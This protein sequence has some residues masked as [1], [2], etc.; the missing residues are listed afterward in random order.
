MSVTP[1][2][3]ATLFLIGASDVPN[4]SNGRTPTVKTLDF[5]LV[6]DLRISS[7]DRDDNY[8]WAGFE[9]AVSAD[10]A[11]NMYIIDPRENRII[12]LDKDGTFIRSIGQKGEGPGEF[13][14]LT[15]MTLLDDQTIVAYD[16]RSPGSFHFFDAG[17]KFVRRQALNGP[18]RNNL[19]DGVLS[20]NGRWIFGR[21]TR[22]QA[23]PNVVFFEYSLF[24]NKMEKLHSL[25]Q[26]QLDG[27]DPSRQG[28]PAFWKKFLA[29][30]IGVDG[31]GLLAYVAY[32]SK[33]EVYTAV[34]TKYEITRWTPDMVEDLRI[35]RDY[36]PIVLSE[37]EIDAIVSPIFAQA[38]EQLPDEHKHILSAAMIK[39]SV[40]LAGFPPAKPPILGLKVTDQ[41]ILVVIHDHSE[42]S[43]R[44]SADLFDQK[45]RF[46][47][48]F[49]HE[50][51]GLK[52]M[53]FKNGYAYTIETVDEENELVRYKIN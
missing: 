24:N 16:I 33:G 19:R 42:I 1:L 48:R 30:R 39:E 26:F 41:G 52:R 22:I 47:G 40:E 3:L 23:S 44:Q 43:G 18:D 6:E 21:T 36:K 9:V 8:V 45:G 12:Q 11:G 38:K 2:M 7:D 17:Y 4:I 50:N 10:K 20:P 37:Q 5:Q 13:R 53:F 35:T 15:G 28:D 49:T 14:A 31:K 46:V 29:D 32:G 51:Y 27:F 25:L 34:G